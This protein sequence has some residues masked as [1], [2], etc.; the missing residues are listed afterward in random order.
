[1]YEPATLTTVCVVDLITPN[2]VELT[3]GNIHFPGAR[4]KRHSV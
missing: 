1:M 2:V 3:V 4:E